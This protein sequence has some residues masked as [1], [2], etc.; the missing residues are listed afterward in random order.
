MTTRL[1]NLDELA[2]SLR[3]AQ[4][5]AYLDDAIASHRAGANRAAIVTLWTTIVYDLIQKIRELA[6]GGDAN[7]VA[8]VQAYETALKHNDIPW[9]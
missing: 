4:S 8:F 1:H 2:G 6:N 3:D 7:A 5:R 9:G